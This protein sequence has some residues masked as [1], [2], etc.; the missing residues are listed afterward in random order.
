MAPPVT[1]QL[2]VVPVFP[3]PTYK[4]HLEPNL[5]A[6][7]DDKSNTNI[8]CFG[9]FAYKNSGI[10]Y[11]DLTGSFPFMSLDGSV[12][13][14]VLYHYELNAILITPIAGLDNLSMFD[15][16]KTQFDELT[17]KGFKIKLNIMDNQATLHIKNS[18]PKMIANCKPLNPTIVK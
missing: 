7:D 13:F 6:I 4:A 1:P 16:Y 2:D 17:A 18:L 8:F 9:E 5:I 15:S 10:V 3:G 11:H 12:C 14:V